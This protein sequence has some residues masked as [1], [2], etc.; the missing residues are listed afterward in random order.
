[1]VDLPD[2][3]ARTAPT[4]ER[5]YIARETE[6]NFVSESPIGTPETPCFAVLARVSD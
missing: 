2:E 1:M 3:N 5:S 4:S 6:W